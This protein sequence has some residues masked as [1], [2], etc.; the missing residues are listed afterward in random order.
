MAGSTLVPAGETCSTTRIGCGKSAGSEPARATRAS[1]PPADAPTTT[2]EGPRGL[3]GAGSE[4]SVT[5]RQAYSLVRRAWRRS[6]LHCRHP[7]GWSATMRHGRDC[8][9]RRSVY[10]VPHA[11]PPSTRVSLHPLRGPR[12]HSP[13]PGSL[14][15]GGRRSCPPGKEPARLRRRARAM[16]W[17][18]KRWRMEGLE[19]VL[20]EEARASVHAAREAADRDARRAQ[21]AAHRAAADAAAQLEALERT[22]TELRATVRRM[23]S[24]A[25]VP[26]RCESAPQPSAE[27]PAVPLAAVRATRRRPAR[28]SMRSSA[29]SELFR[30]TTAG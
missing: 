9:Q 29:L 6:R 28:A 27:E 10:H 19:Q 16:T 30:A 8:A 15:A 2:T 24:A 14:L 21:R 18:V 13:A 26:E 11:D 1:T 4:A 20:T 5:C 22:G 7:R 23:R 12:V 25:D 17:V 3:S